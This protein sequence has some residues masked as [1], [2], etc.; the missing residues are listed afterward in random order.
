MVKKL[1]RYFVF[2]YV[3]MHFLVS[4]IILILGGSSL[5]YQLLHSIFGPFYVGRFG[6]NFE[7]TSISWWILDFIY[8]LITYF[9]VA[10]TIL[11][12]INWNEPESTEVLQTPPGILD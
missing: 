7:Y 3:V 9:S 10:L 12:F 11:I 6:F 8:L 2:I 4:P 5:T 1:T